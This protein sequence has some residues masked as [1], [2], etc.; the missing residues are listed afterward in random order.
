MK[1]F[2]DTKFYENQNTIDLISIGI[3]SEDIAHIPDIIEGK[4]YY[5]I[6]KDFNLKKAWNAYRITIVK[7]SQFKYIAKKVYWL[8]INVFKPIYRDLMNKETSKM[9]YH[10]S[11]LFNDYPMD[12]K[13]FKKLIKKY[14][15]TNEQIAKEIESF[16]HAPCR[17]ENGQS[18]TNNTPLLSVLNVPVVSLEDFDTQFY[19]YNS[20]Y[21]WVVFAQLFKGVINFPDGFPK[22][23]NDL[24]Q[25]LERLNET[26]GYNCDEQGHSYKLQKHSNYPKKDNSYDALANAIWN[27]LLYEF[28]NKL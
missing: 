10:T 17:L 19:G 24:K 7:E 14:G 21:S 20:A 27:K 26:L 22:Y 3:V 6:S 23:C 12:Y 25:E 28:L 18:I 5:A 4:E 1:Y 11:K 16:I 13:S 2:I 9:P 15:K 8:R